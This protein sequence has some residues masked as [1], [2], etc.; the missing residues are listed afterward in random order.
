[1]TPLFVDEGGSLSA[2]SRL[3]ARCRVGRH[4]AA[5]SPRERARRGPS[6]TVE[7]DYRSAAVLARGEDE[8]E[9]EDDLW[10]G[11]VCASLLP[12]TDAG[13][14]PAPDRAPTDEWSSAWASARGAQYVRS[15]A[16]QCRRRLTGLHRRHDVDDPKRLGRRSACPARPLFVLACGVERVPRIRRGERCGAGPMRVVDRAQVRERAFS[17]VRGC[18]QVKSRDVV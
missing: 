4:G 8:D 3:A 12:F 10:I 1:L 2:S 13:A 9:R 16:Q 18:A 17:D 7:P 6:Q 14:G 11:A 15:L 5:G